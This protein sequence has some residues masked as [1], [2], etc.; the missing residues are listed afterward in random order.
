MERRRVDVCASGLEQCATPLRPDPG[1]ESFELGPL[2][3][4]TFD[5]RRQVRQLVAGEMKIAAH[6][7][8]CSV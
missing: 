7:E 6:P 1:K 3:D 8:K 4:P 5:R 2:Y